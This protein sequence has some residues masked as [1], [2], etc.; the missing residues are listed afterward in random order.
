M[1]ENDIAHIFQD[2]GIKPEVLP[3]YDGPEKYAQELIPAPSADAIE[4]TYY[5]NYST[6]ILGEHDN[7]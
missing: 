3:K 6:S 1:N 5:T 4:T 7:G 2:L